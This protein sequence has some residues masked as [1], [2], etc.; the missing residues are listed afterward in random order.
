M[1]DEDPSM[2]IQMDQIQIDSIPKGLN[3][4][5]D[6]YIKN[7]P[8]ESDRSSARKLNKIIK[9][10]RKVEHISKVKANYKSN[11]TLKEN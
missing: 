6:D 1:K 8:C 7:Y 3:P 2:L 4:I 5:S 11:Q 9:L 10:S